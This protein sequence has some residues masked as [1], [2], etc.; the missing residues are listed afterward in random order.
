MTG[1][2]RPL[3]DGYYEGNRHGGRTTLKAMDIE[4]NVGKADGKEGIGSKEIEMIV[5]MVIINYLLKSLYNYRLVLLLP[6][7]STY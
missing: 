1:S 4:E 2:I 7:V 3:A 6:T 5:K